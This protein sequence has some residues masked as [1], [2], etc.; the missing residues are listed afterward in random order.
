MLVHV[1]VFPD[2]PPPTCASPDV[3][4]DWWIEPDI[5]ESDLGIV[6]DAT[7]S[8]PGANEA[9]EL[10]SQVHWNLARAKLFCYECP[11]LW[12]CRAT[13]WDEPYHVFGGLTPSERLE[14]R[15]TGIVPAFTPYRAARSDSMRVRADV[16]RLFREGEGP[17]AIAEALGR[18]QATIFNHIKGLLADARQER[19]EQEPWGLELPVPSLSSL[20]A[21]MIE[22]FR[23]GPE[24]SSDYTRESA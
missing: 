21:T 3:E 13:S 16:R 2:E 4:S 17:Q 18:S 15:S 12:R 24:P 14:A 6:R 5:Y 22:D 1:Q 10:R 7:G 19:E 23:R 20:G 9:T 8:N 11:L